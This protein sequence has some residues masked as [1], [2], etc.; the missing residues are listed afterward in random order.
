[1]PQL[2]EHI[3][4]IARKKQRDIL[5]VT[6]EP[7]ATIYLGEYIGRDI[8]EEEPNNYDYESD[9]KRT[10]VCQWLDDHKISWQECGH[11]ASECGWMS[12][13][14]QIYIDVPYDKNNAEYQLLEAYFEYPDGSPRMK[15]I[16]LYC[17][18]LEI[19]MVNAHHDEPGFWE[20]WAENF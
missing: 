17:L 12:Y 3:D 9:P 1:M 6:F 18:A 4:A 10:E 14:G 11:F 8:L 2:L 16:V 13:C 7:R 5:F 20:N 15:N 19:A